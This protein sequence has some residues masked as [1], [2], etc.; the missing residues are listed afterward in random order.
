[1]EGLEF[2]TKEFLMT[3][4]GQVTLVTLITECIK[5]YIKKLDPKIISLILSLGISLISQFVFKQDFSVEGII[6]ALFNSVIVLLSSIGGYE[7]ILKGIQRKIENNALESA[8]T[9]YTI[10]NEE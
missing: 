7:A 3:F 10:N 4:A 8:E 9:D 2:F 6:L 5:L 1:M